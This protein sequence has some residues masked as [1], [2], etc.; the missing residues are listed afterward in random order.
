MAISPWWW[1]QVIAELDEKK[2]EALE[3]TWRKVNQVQLPYL[4]SCQQSCQS[5]L[6]A[7]GGPRYCKICALLDCSA[8]SAPVIGVRIRNGQLLT[9]TG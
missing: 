9:G 2:R 6:D 8:D 4:A 3:K 5:H 7:L 1:R